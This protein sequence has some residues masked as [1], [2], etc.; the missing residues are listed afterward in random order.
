MKEQE[1]FNS[2]LFLVIVSIAGRLLF[3]FIGF[4]G[5]WAYPIMA[6]FY[7]LLIISGITFWISMIYLTIRMG[8][9]WM[10]VLTFFIPI[11]SLYDYF[12]IYKP[13]LKK[14]Y[15]QKHKTGRE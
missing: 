10:A 13:R 8:F 6:F 1:F 11:V 12:G 5:G 14:S 3:S 9:G 15:I 4:F 2:V 7:T